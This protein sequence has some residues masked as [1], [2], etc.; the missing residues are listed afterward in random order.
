MKVEF[1]QPGMFFDENVEFSISKAKIQEDLQKLI[2]KGANIEIRPF[3]C[4][5]SELLNAQ[6]FKIEYW[7]SAYNDQKIVLISKSGTRLIVGS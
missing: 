3:N 1:F 2:A 7:Q 5:L 4:S 6:I